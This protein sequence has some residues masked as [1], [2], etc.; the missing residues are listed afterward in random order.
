MWQR[1]SGR[2][3][4]SASGN[5]VADRLRQDGLIVLCGQRIH[6]EAK[7]IEKRANEQHVAGAIAVENLAA[8]GR[9]AK[10]DESLDVGYP[11]HGARRVV[12]Q[13][14]SLI[15]GLKNAYAVDETQT[16]EVGAPRP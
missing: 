5:A 10:Y 14:S 8:E 13:R 3:V 11:S 9:S 6:C 7:D 4:N 1:N 16:A 12:V 15:I 2:V